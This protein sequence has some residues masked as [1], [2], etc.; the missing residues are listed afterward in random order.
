VLDPADVV[1]VAGIRCTNGVRTG[2]DLL[3]LAPD[4]TEA[5]VAGDCLLHAGMTTV[6]AMSTYAGSHQRRRGVRQLRRALPLLDGLAASPPES[7]LRLL[8]HQAGLTDVLVNVPVYDLG[9]TFLG[10]VD[11]LEDTTGLSLEYDGQYHRELGQQTRDNRREERLER[12]GLTVLRV[13]ALDMQEPASLVHRIRQ[14]HQ[15][16]RSSPLPRN[17]VHQLRAA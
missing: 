8:C 14:A 17:W 11:L 4:L 13:T 6:P 3:R 5:V 9:G 15:A 12:V 10:I 2:F 7:R 1:E 16:C